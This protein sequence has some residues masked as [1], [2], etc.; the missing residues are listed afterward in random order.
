MG[1]WLSKKLLKFNYNQNQTGQHVSDD[2]L[3]RG[4]ENCNNATLQNCFF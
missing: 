1:F 3:H 4:T 2:V